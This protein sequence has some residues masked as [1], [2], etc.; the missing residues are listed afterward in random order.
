MTA[1]HR[2]LFVLHPPIK[3]G[4]RSP[5]LRTLLLGDELNWTRGLRGLY[6]YGVHGEHLVVIYLLRRFCL[7]AVAPTLYHV[8]I[9][10]GIPILLDRSL[11]VPLTA[12]AKTVEE[13][14]CCSKVRQLKVGRPCKL[15]NIYC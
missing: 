8:G 12:I 14:R 4:S 5:G 11:T 6:N 13:F 3:G 2:L 1:P 15:G 9:C 10:P 7:L